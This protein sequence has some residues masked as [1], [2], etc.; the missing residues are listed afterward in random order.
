M[1]ETMK[2]AG[3][4]P[5]RGSNAVKRNAS[6]GRERWRAV[7]NTYLRGLTDD[8]FGG[9][10]LQLL[11]STLVTDS[12]SPVKAMINRIKF[13]MLANRLY[14]LITGWPPLNHTT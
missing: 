5:K 1:N 7:G 12:T 3:I 14:T 8:G 2:Q 13:R 4:P 11:A 9:F 10:E 6:L